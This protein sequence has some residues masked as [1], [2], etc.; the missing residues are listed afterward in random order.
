MASKR[1][2]LIP[3]NRKNSYQN[4]KAMINDMQTKRKTS[5]EYAKMKKEDLIKTLRSLIS[6]FDK[7]RHACVDLKLENNWLHR[8]VGL[9]E[10]QIIYLKKVAGRNGGFRDI[11][12]KRNQNGIDENVYEV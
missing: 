5:S 8:R 11:N 9:L 7:T 1:K 12:I 10:E 2:N 3:I 4:M 6:N